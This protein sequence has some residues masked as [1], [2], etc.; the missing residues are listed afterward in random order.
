MAKGKKK[1]TVVGVYPDEGE[2]ITEHVVADDMNGAVAEF[3]KKRDAED[4]G[5]SIVEIFEGHCTSVM[6]V[7]W[8][9]HP[10]SIKE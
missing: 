4:T 1:F 9:D 6:E 2:T 5:I 3:W 7:C 8:I 10:D